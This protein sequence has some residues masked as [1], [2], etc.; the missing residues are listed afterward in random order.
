MEQNTDALKESI[1]NIFKHP[2][3]QIIV[4]HLPSP[5]NGRRQ[6]G[7]GQRIGLFAGTGVGK[8]FAYL[9][10]A[11]LFAV[12]M[13]RAAWVQGAQHELDPGVGLAQHEAHRESG[14][15]PR[16]T[17]CGSRHRCGTTGRK[18]KQSGGKISIRNLCFAVEFGYCR[19]G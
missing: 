10:P 4:L 14:P 1:R 18:G 5:G 19:T 7:R 12:A 8:S 3:G 17:P 15:P 6:A 13:A 2:A 11:I 16:Q 9:V